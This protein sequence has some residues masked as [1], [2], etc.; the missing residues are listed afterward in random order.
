VSSPLLCLERTLAGPTC[1]S[2]SPGIMHGERLCP[3]YKALPDSY[4]ALPCCRGLQQCNRRRKRRVLCSSVVLVV[5]L[6]VK[7]CAS[8]CCRRLLA[9][10]VHQTNV[11][12]CLVHAC[13]SNHCCGRCRGDLSEGFG[14]TFF[15]GSLK[16]P[17]DKLAAACTRVTGL[18]TAPAA[19][20]LRQLGIL[21]WAAAC[22]L[23][24]RT[25]TQVIE[26]VQWLMSRAVG[27]KGSR[28]G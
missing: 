11:S 10:V 14:A 26:K 15:P 22:C 9:V 13:L 4:A 5:V 8:C 1:D 25:A 24:Q 16:P 12:P 6:V 21:Q 23:A 17:V 18:E 2:F 20:S 27:G 7:S 19:R 28:C 3:G